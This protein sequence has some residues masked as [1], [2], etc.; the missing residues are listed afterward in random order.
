MIY[1]TLVLQSYITMATTPKDQ[2]DQCP[3]PK[4]VISCLMAFKNIVYFQ[5]IS[6]PP[7]QREFEIQEIPAGG[8]G[9]ND[10]FG[11]QM[12]FDSI[13]VQKSFLTN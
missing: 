7:P 13:Q 10:Q 12:P 3:V 4:Q 5:K 6:I 11:F 1:A 2:K 9:L 8:G